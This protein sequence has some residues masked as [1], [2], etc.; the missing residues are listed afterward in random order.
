MQD[1]PGKAGGR[2][3]A[4]I[5]VQRVAVAAQPVQQRL[6]RQSGRANSRSGARSGAAGRDGPRSPPKPPSPRAKIERFWVHSRAP[7]GAV[8]RGL[9]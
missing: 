5:G 1:R 3:E 9:G 4:G 6:L 8:T 2:G 7:S